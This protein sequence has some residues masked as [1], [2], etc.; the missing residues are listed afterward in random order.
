MSQSCMPKK[1]RVK[2]PLCV[3]GLLQRIFGLD[4]MLVSQKDGL[5][6]RKDR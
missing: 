4:A 3:V 6:I 5:A 2:P 1:C